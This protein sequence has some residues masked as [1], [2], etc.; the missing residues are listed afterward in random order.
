MPNEKYLPVMTLATQIV[1]AVTDVPSYIEVV[2]TES[3]FNPP[4]IIMFRGLLPSGIFVFV[5]LDLVL[6]Y[7]KKIKRIFLICFKIL[8]AI[9]SKQRFFSTGAGNCK[10]K[11]FDQSV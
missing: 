9:I 6:Y 1:P 7:T 5:S 3:Y 8:N 11:L 10:K 2:I 4:L